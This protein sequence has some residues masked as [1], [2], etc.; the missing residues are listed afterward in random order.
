M[1]EDDK[2]IICGKEGYCG[3]YNSKK[4]KWEY[5]CFEHYLQ[6]DGCEIF[7]HP[8]TAESLKG[9]TDEEISIIRKVIIEKAPIWL[10]DFQKALTERNKKKALSVF[11]KQ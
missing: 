11:K 4:E 3:L 5:F 6:E 8:M 10:E 1:E 9:Y 2:C 7:G